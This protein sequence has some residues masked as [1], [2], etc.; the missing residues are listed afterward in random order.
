MVF[1]NRT[2]LLPVV[3]FKHF[4]FDIKGAHP[5]EI[6]RKSHSIGRFE[7]LCF[8]PREFIWPATPGR[9]WND[10]DIPI[11]CIKI[12]ADIGTTAM[13]VAGILTNRYAIRCTGTCARLPESR[14]IVNTQIRRLDFR[15]MHYTCIIIRGAQLLSSESLVQKVHQFITVYG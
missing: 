9:Q 12:S 2:P 1:H 14:P 4:N 6:L 3:I 8:K 11:L 10:V 5:H 15:K 13:Y 7:I